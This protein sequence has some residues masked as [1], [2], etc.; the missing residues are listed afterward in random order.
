M[1]KKKPEE[2]PRRGIQRNVTPIPVAE[3]TKKNG[4]TC[5][6]NRKKCDYLG[7]KDAC[8]INGARCNC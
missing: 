2:K 6:G 5:P 1:A 7:K 3:T 8:S 4:K